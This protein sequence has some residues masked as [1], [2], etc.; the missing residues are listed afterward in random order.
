MINTHAHTQ[1]REQADGECGRAVS[2]RESA[3]CVEWLATAS[4]RQSCQTRKGISDTCKHTLRRH[5]YMCVCVCVCVTARECM[6]NKIKNIVYKCVFWCFRCAL[7]LVFCLAELHFT[8]LIGSHAIEFIDR[9]RHARACTVLCT[10]KASTSNMYACTYVFTAK[11]HKNMRMWKR[12]EHF[13]NF[14]GW[15]WVNLR[16]SATK[17]KNIYICKSHKKYVF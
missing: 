1:A 6:L 2:V 17:K 14:Y 8:H 13:V 11:E 16:F 9:H 5:M 4:S 3:V 7:L 12:T 10:V 15:C